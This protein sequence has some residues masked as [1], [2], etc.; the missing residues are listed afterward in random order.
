MACKIVSDPIYIKH[1]TGRHHPERPE[2]YTSIINALI[3]NGLN[4]HLPARLATKEEVTLCHTED[5]FDL[6]DKEIT[7]LKTSKWQFGQ[8]TLSTGDVEISPD[9]FDVALTAV[10]GVLNAVDAVMKGITKRVFCVVRPPGHHA[11]SSLG[12]GFCLFNSVAVGA[13]Y[14]Q[15]KYGLK[16]VAIVDWDVHHGNGT[17]EIFYKDPS[18]FYFSTHQWPFY[19]GTGWFDETGEGPG[20]GFTLNSPIGSSEK[21]RDEVFSA[22]R[23]KLV[24]AMDE[25]KPELLLISAGFDAHY[26]DPLGGFNLSEKDFAELTKIV[27]E[28][29]NKH[30]NG[31]IIS[32]LEGGYNVDAIALCAVDHV[33]TLSS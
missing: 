10:G 12:M 20:K 18:V 19:P 27:V 5:Y 1:K 26:A 22:F 7:N 6:V 23:D 21:S 32:V 30:A 11:T 8:P 2:R 31:K 17:Q 3:K 29:A 28:I 9:S 14:A 15:K 13:R 4:D 24:P 25:F 16:R 33:R